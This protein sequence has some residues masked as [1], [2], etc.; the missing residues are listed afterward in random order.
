VEVQFAVDDDQLG[1]LLARA[2]LGDLGKIRVYYC[3]GYVHL[4]VR[5]EEVQG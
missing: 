5:L 3:P 1:L 4:R 2:C